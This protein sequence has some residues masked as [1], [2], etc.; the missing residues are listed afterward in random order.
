[1]A[2]DDAPREWDALVA[3]LSESAGG[4]TADDPA[5]EAM[6]VSLAEAASAAMVSRSA[7]RSWYRTDQVP[8]RMV[9]GPHGP[10]REVPLDAVLDRARISERLARRA[11]AAVASE[12]GT[13]VAGARTALAA[14][15]AAL[16][17]AEDRAERAEAALRVA[18]E[19]A[20][21]AEARLR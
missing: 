21:A 11:E 2:P 5:G 18:L 3:R 12:L 10:Q 14:L 1:M 8:S 9:D 13:D 7:L 4:A 16:V 19:R 6:W 15:E 20:A 17:R